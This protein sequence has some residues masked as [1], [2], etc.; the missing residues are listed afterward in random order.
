MGKKRKGSN[1]MEGTGLRGMK[2]AVSDDEGDVVGDEGVYGEVDMWEKE[3]D[4]EMMETMKRGRGGRGDD[5]PSE[6]LAL[7]GTDSDS[8]LELPTIKKLRK[9]Q[10]DKERSEKVVDDDGEISDSDLGSEEEE[11]DVRRWGSKKK[12]YYGGNTGEEL[13]HELGDSDLEEDK[14]E[15]QEAA[16]LQSRQIEMMDEEDF[17]DAFVVK[18]PESS[19]KKVEPKDSL[20]PDLSKLSRKEQVQLF[21]Q[22]SPE[23][24]GVVADFQLRMGDAVKLAKVTALADGGA[25]PDGPVLDFVRNK[26]ELLLNYSTNILAYLMF[27]SRGVSMALHP[28]TGRLVQYRQLIDRLDP[29]DK[30]VMPQVEELLKRKEKGETV[31]QMV[32]EERRK[33]RRELERKKQKPL[34]FNKQ[35]D[36]VEEEAKSKKRRKNKR[37]AQENDLSGLEGLTGDEKMAL[38]L[39]QVIKKSKNNEDLEDDDE[40][41]DDMELETREGEAEAETENL[42]SNTYN[43]NNDTVEGE[44]EA[45]KRAITYKIAKNKGLMPKRSKLQR[46]PR[47]KNRMKFEKAKKRRKGAVRE[48]RDQNKKYSGEASGLNARVKKGVK[49][50]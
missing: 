11:E 6:V 35:D 43:D 15:E 30:I 9:K 24:A 26:L 50:N 3:Q 4:K 48:V 16:M 8:D 17:L 39:Y 2:N 29:M 14:I 46:N 19:E 7:S 13:E 1:R 45:E 27:K 41:L 23:F 31:K 20:A 42:V 36:P 40:E 33:L 49:I 12:Y 34:K 18:K 32:K 28:V 25:L 37:K 38:Q 10:R 22:Q 47:V 21:K 44:D 5:G